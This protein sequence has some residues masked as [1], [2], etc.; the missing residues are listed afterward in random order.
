MCPD[1]LVGWGKTFQTWG[2]NRQGLCDVDVPHDPI[3]AVSRGLAGPCTRR[4]VQTPWIKTPRG[5]MSAFSSTRKMRDPTFFNLLCSVWSPIMG[6][7]K[8]WARG[9]LTCIVPQLHNCPKCC[10]WCNLHKWA[11]GHPAELG[12][13]EVLCVY[14]AGN[15]DKPWPRPEGVAQ[16]VRE[17]SGL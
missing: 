17:Q 11:W 15:S 12:L 8:P 14:Q 13:K 5:R 1:V 2:S 7:V 9:R 6:Q 16:S 10:W 4:H 3:T